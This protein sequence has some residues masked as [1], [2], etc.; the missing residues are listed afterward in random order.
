MEKVAHISAGWILDFFGLQIARRPIVLWLGTLNIVG[1]GGPNP[2]RYPW[3]Y[4]TLYASFIYKLKHEGH[5]DPESGKIPY[6]HTRDYNL[7]G[8]N[9]TQQRFHIH[10]GGG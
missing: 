7:Y 8:S 9:I 10:D 5:E 3:H 6:T 1:R 2:I 4:Y